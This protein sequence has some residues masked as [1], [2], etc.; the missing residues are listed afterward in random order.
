MGTWPSRAWTSWRSKNQEGDWSRLRTERF[1]NSSLAPTSEE[2]V[3]N[4]DTEDSE[5]SFDKEDK[6]DES[7]IEGKRLRNDRRYW[8]FNESGSELENRRP[9]LYRALFG[10]VR[11][12]GQKDVPFA[13][14][15]YCCAL[16][17]MSLDGHI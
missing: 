16:Q 8:V 14:C 12:K 13:S 5:P 1:F 15:N 9:L 17:H 10:W 3:S 7:V 2:L 11:K 6:E 4:A